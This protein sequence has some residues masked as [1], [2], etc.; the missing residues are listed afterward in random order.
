[1]DSFLLISKI[2][3]KLF[4]YGGLM[5]HLNLWEAEMTYIMTGEENGRAI[6]DVPSSNPKVGDVIHVLS[7]T[8]VSDIGGFAFMKEGN[9]Y[10]LKEQL[11]DFDTGATFGV[12]PHFRVGFVESRK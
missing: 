10:Q 1:M 11:A 12:I 2:D 6:W 8:I 5:R 7:R 3:K 9:A 4:I